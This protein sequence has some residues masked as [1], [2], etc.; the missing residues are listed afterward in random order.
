LSLA[1]INF[2]GKFKPFFNFIQLTLGRLFELHEFDP[3]Y[4]LLSWEFCQLIPGSED[5]FPV[6]EGQPD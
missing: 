1:A 6:M 2:Q 4:H 5:G 3:A